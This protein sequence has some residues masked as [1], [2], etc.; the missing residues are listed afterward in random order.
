[1]GTIDKTGSDYLSVNKTQVQFNPASSQLFPDPA[2]R[3][4]ISTEYPFRHI[5]TP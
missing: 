4:T 1:M 5:S 3:Q 2:S